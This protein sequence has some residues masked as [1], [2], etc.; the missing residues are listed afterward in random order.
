MAGKRK[1][2]TSEDKPAAKRA[3]R[4]SKKADDATDEV[5]ASAPKK[6]QAAGWDFLKAPKGDQLK[7]PAKKAAAPV[8]DAEFPPL[9]DEDL[10]VFDG[11]IPAPSSSAQYRVLAWNVNGLRAV[12]K[13]D[14]YFRAYIARE[15]PDVL[16]LSE[17]KI[18][19]AS[20]GAVRNI[21]P[22]YGHQYWKCATQKG[23][24]G[25]AMFSKTKPLRVLDEITV[26]GQVDDEG[27]FLALEFEKFW[28]VH[29]YVPNAGQKLDRLEYRTKKWDT[30]L[31]A[32]LK[33]LE[34][35]KPVV[36]CGDLNVAYEEI[37]IH[38]PKGNRN[39]SAGFT[40]AERESFGSLLA[41]G[42]V[43]TFRS[44]YPETQTFSYFSYRFGAREKNKGWRLDYFVA[45]K[46]LLPHVEDSAIRSAIT[47][48]DHL[49]IALTLS[50]LDA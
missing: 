14:N 42:F 45:S 35:T 37:D 46:A 32:K 7:K 34:A 9:A 13:K 27:R 4:A 29:T 48:S 21:L 47:G 36:W 15:D 5:P 30:A 22:Q 40:D 19:D 39:K 20:L 18:D 41:D 1:Q 6:A 26:D 31:F 33:E 43:D 10:K 3:T 38:D 16:C 8:A 44:K 23:Y 25:T 24:S 28:L 17:T 50:G 49:P 11:V 12:L 2:T